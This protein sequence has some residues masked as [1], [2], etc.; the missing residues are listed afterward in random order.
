MMAHPTP[1]I[2]RSRL[3]GWDAAQLD[4]VTVYGGTLHLATVPGS[5]EP[6][7]SPSGDFGGLTLPK[8]VA[9]GPDN[10]I[11]VLDGP[12]GIVKRY[13]P[14]AERFVPLPCLGGPGGAQRQLGGATALAISCWDDLYIVEGAN[15]RLQILARETLK[16]RGIWGPFAWRQGRLVRIAGKQKLDPATGL[17]T[18]DLD[19]PA[20]AWEPSAVAFGSKATVLVSDSA[21]N[22]IHVFDRLG[23]WRTAFDGEDGDGVTLSEPTA[24]AVDRDGRIY[25]VESG[26]SAVAVLAPDGSFLERVDIPEAI[27]DRFTP[28]AVSIDGEGVIWISD[29]VSG[30]TSR[31][32]RAPT[33]ACLPPQQ[34]PLVPADCPLLAFDAEGNAILGDPRRPCLM[35]SNARRYE[36]WGQYWS[37]PFDSGLPGC[38][39]DRIDLDITLP[40]GTR[41]AVETTTAD[42]ELTAS[43]IASLPI[44]QWTLTPLSALDGARWDCA[45]RSTPGRFLWLR[46]TFES[47]GAATPD[48]GAIQVTFPRTTSRRYLPAVFSEEPTSADFLDRFLEVFDRH[49]GEALSPSD[50]FAAYLDPLATPAAEAGESGADFLDW[51]GGWIGLALDRNWPVRRRRALVAQAPRLFRWRGTVYGLKRFVALYIERE[52]KVIEHFRLRRWLTLDEGQLGNDAAL[53]GPEI[54]RRLQLDAYSEIGRFQLVDGGDPLTDPFDAFAHRCTLFVPVGNGFSDADMADLEAVLAF[55][56]PA[57]VE[58][59]VRLMRPRFSIDCGTVI[60]VNTIIGRDAGTVRTDEAVLGEEIRLPEA[61]SRFRLQAGLRVGVDTIFE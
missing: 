8:S 25:V 35:R 28:P 29:R 43:E 30:L 5:V 24:L 40:F 58:V 15:R 37:N 57:H 41:L 47:E 52:P 38:V 11:Y 21:S 17:A 18:G 10:S 7:A 45:I 49:R 12:Q 31:I 3:A 48:I 4:R 16:L 56:K 19:W 36:T 60:G 33:G 13:D 54:V 55:A 32:C 61:G 42:E 34:V 26:K 22:L 27:A 44:D 1:S 53:W 59:E 51:L 6:L 14:C 20:D 46:L 39:W 23:L 2:L 50:R 9:T